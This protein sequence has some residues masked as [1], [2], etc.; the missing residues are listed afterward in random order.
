MTMSPHRAMS[1]WILILCMLFAVSLANPVSPGAADS[2]LLDGREYNPDLDQ[3]GTRHSV[4]QPQPAAAGAAADVSAAT[5]QERTDTGIDVDADDDDEFDDDGDIEEEVL[6]KLEGTAIPKRVVK[7]LKAISESDDYLDGKGNTVKSYTPVKREQ[8]AGLGEAYVFS[9]NPV[10]TREDSEEFKYAELHFYA[11]NFVVDENLDNDEEVAI[12]FYHATSAECHPIGAFN[13]KIPKNG[14]LITDVTSILD[15]VVID[16]HAKVNIAMY[17]G[18]VVVN[19]YRHQLVP[20]HGSQE[21]KLVKP[22]VFVYTEDSSVKKG[23]VQSNWQRLAEKMASKDSDLPTSV[24]TSRRH[25]SARSANVTNETLDNTV[26]LQPLG[27]PDPTTTHIAFSFFAEQNMRRIKSNRR[28]ARK[29]RQKQ[30]KSKNMMLEPALTAEEEAEQ[31]RQ[32]EMR[33]R[34]KNLSKP[35]PKEMDMVE[36]S[37]APADGTC[38]RHEMHADFWTIGWGDHILAPSSFQAYYCMGRC[39]FPIAKELHPSNHA[40]IQSIMHALGIQTG[41]PTPCCVPEKMKPLTLLYIDDELNVYLKKYD[42]MTVVSC[43]CR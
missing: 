6:R 12:S 5:A 39:S 37:I 32:E 16:D 27:K 1:L 7:V 40:I 34:K 3:V 19:G 10:T 28:R 4:H 31:E 33:S 36:G 38:Q 22:F 11:K 29:Q 9:L 14:W 25:R 2:D 15:H 18:E 23:D 24:P 35:R 21:E 13:L 17:V 8:C 26:P 42:D 20:A 41:V 30:R 43:G